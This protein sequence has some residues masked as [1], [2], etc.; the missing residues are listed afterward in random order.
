MRKAGKVERRAKFRLYAAILSHDHQVN[1]QAMIAAAAGVEILGSKK[2]QMLG[3]M[4]QRQYRG[5]STKIQW[6]KKGQAA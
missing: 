1:G 3:D 5:W 4:L 6:H 2:Q